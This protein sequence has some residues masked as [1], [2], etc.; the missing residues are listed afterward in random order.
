MRD[1]ALTTALLILF[2][3]WIA[4]F[5]C[6][7]DQM[8][9]NKSTS[10][11]W[12]SLHVTVYTAWLIPLAWYIFDGDAERTAMWVGANASLHYAVDFWTSRINSWFWQRDRRHDFFVMVGLDQLIHY[13]C[14]LSLYAVL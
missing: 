13:A 3:H 10:N 5:V 9:V 7:T 8:A 2:T 1:I 14:L 11:F 12:L 6:Q 4:D